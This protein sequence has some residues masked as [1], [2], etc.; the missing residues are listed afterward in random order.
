MTGI[1]KEECD[2]R[3]ADIKAR[4][5]DPETVEEIKRPQFQILKKYNN[6]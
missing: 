5:N 2:K 3:I 4:E 6:G 1:S